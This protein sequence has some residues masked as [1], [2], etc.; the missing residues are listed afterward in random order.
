[1]SQF[2]CMVRSV[3]SGEFYICVYNW[4]YLSLRLCWLFIHWMRTPYFLAAPSSCGCA[5]NSHAPNL[6]CSFG[7]LCVVMY[8]YIQLWS[9]RISVDF[10]V[11]EFP[12]M[13]FHIWVG[14]YKSNY[15]NRIQYFVLFVLGRIK[16]FRVCMVPSPATIKQTKH[17]FKGQ[18]NSESIPSK[19]LLN[20]LKSNHSKLL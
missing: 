19:T 16:I 4:F 17:S 8:V 9:L 6:R 3:I 11:I 1:M 14:Q 2:E 15:T 20:N 7:A 13:R 5:H 10:L 12:Q 18:M